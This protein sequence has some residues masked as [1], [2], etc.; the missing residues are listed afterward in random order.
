[1]R[2]TMIGHSTVLVETSGKKILTDPYFGTWGNLAYARPVPPA[3]SR[4]E[5][6]QVDGV[7]ISHEHW[8]HVDGKFLRS[9][10]DVPVIVP[11][12]TRWLIRLFS[13]GELLGIAAWESTSIGEITITAVPA[14]HITSTVGYVLQ[15]EEKQVYFA[16][17]SYYRPFMR[18]IGNKFQLDVAL[19]PV[20]TY[21]LP[22]T[23]GEEQAV[24]AAQ[25]LKAAVVIPIHLGLRP[26]SPLLRTDQTPEH[27]AK[28]MGEQG[29]K[30]QVVIL[31][32]GES[33][34]L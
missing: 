2:I 20:T 3:M 30:C 23:M 17:D 26:R 8:D 6:Q 32:E 28:R 18:D 5:L 11:K 9:L 29:V 13:G 21:R 34:T 33:W 25:D 1:M 24:R 14:A 19:M 16:G 22:M 12:L 31:A 7:L 10:G 15:G 4:Q 27:F